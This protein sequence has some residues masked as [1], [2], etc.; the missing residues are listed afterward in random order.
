MQAF[1]EELKTSRAGDSCTLKLSEASC[2]FI[3]TH[4]DL[5]CSPQADAF[6]SE[7]NLVVLGLATDTSL[8]VALK[9]SLPK[10]GLFY[11]NEVLV[12]QKIKCEAVPHIYRQWRL[13]EDQLSL[14]AFSM[15]WYR[16]CLFDVIA[17]TRV[18]RVLA[19]RVVAAVSRALLLAH[20]EQVTHCDL[21]SENV[22]MEDSSGRGCVLGDWDLACDGKQAQMASYKTGTLEYNPPES[23][24]LSDVSFAADAFRMG[25]LMYSMLLGMT[26]VW[27]TGATLLGICTADNFVCID[28]VLQK[29][30]FCRKF[31]VILLRLLAQG[32]LPTILLADVYAE[33]LANIF[34]S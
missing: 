21:K 31:E 17:S 9:I 8:S 6:V 20:S 3:H 22:F 25:A 27:S 29:N 32:G 2:A 12:L 7:R 11:A 13:E 10:N 23:L 4:F 34:H 19:W 24:G 33:A 5:I 26:P 28:P 14:E 16:L 18:T 15:P 30:F 1:L